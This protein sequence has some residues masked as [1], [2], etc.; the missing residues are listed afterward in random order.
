MNT[1]STAAT[2]LA[3][4][5]SSFNIKENVHNAARDHHDHRWFCLCY[6]CYLS[7]LR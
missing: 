2:R 4:I 5:T 7:Y 3:A 6:L 1:T